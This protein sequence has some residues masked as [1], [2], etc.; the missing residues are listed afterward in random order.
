[1]I[2]FIIRNYATPDCA[3]RGNVFQ[4][5]LG[6]KEGTVPGM[7]VKMKPASSRRF[8]WSFSSG[9]QTPFRDRLAGT[10]RGWSERAKKLIPSDRYRL[11]YPG[12]DPEYMRTLGDSIF[13]PAPI[14]NVP[15][16]WRT[17]EVLE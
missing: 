3:A 5:P 4:Y 8:I 7:D 10:L 6:V 12:T 14:G 15:D 9:H 13:A 17:Y 2:P 16:T 11:I 1:M